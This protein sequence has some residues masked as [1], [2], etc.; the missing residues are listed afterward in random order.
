L[1][2]Q[3]CACGSIEEMAMTPL[4]QRMLDAMVLRGFAARTVEAYIHAVVG[5]T[6]HHRCSPDL[7]TAQ[8]V[9][10]YMLHLH[11]ERKLSFS[12]VNQAASAFK[13]FYGTVLGLD[14]RPFDIPY[15]RV[16]QRVPELLSRQEVALLLAYAP[17]ATASAFLRLAYATGLRLNE[18]CHLRWRDV[19]AAPDRMCI[20]VRCGKGGKGRLV[21]LT[22]DTLAVLQQWHALQPLRPQAAPGED[23]PDWVFTTRS[24]RSKPLF[25]QSPQRWYRAAASAGGLTKHGGLHTLRHCYATHLLE[26]G[27]DVYSL[28]Q[29]LGHSQV[30]T[31]DRYLHLVRPDAAVGARGASL[32]LLQAL[33]ALQHLPSPEPAWAP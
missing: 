3:A 23:A 22:P 26:S 32:A 18:L 2:V 14:A 10:A 1:I 8:Q 4:R 6:R 19:H 12:T 25:D 28:Q 30:N 16:P 5:L 17:H 33:P 21:P 20:H 11:R 27:V 24:D 29:W 7:L 15:A 9:Q 13:F 31:T